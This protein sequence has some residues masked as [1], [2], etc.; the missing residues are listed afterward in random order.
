[1]PEP[2]KRTALITGGSMGIGYELAKLF[3]QDGCSLILVASRA[4]PLEETAQNLRNSYGVEVRTIARDLSE[5]SVARDIFAEL[6]SAGI[7]VEYLVNNAGF[8]ALGA[9]AETD[10]MHNLDMI[11]VNV[12]ALAE[13]TGLYLPEM[14]KRRSGR[15]LNVAS[16]AS[17]QAGP[18]M[19]VYY[20]SKA[21]VTS[22]S[23][24]LANEV[25]GTGVTVS[26]L[27]PGPTATYFQKR[28]GTE[29]SK[30]F[31]LVMME[32]A[33]VARIGYRGMLNGKPLIIPGLINKLHFQL[34]RI[35]PRRLI[36]H[37]VRRAQEQR[38]KG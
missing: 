21:F 29:R 33:A 20:A 9:F 8:G 2:L 28:A 38:R 14:I 30:V 15:I 27:C 12:T 11:A 17:F 1:M 25:C 7:T 23:E 5:P 10:L 32:A 16:T 35:L 19:A 4:A 31:Q 37:L 3:A 24:A 18:L 36:P 34:I 6:Q 22:F 13:L 26:V